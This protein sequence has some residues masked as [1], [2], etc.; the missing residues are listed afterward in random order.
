[1]ARTKKSTLSATSTTKKSRTATKVAEENTLSTS[2]KTSSANSYT[3]ERVSISELSSAQSLTDTDLVLVSTTNGQVSKNATMRTV[4]DY[5]VSK[6]PTSPSTGGNISPRTYENYKSIKNYLTETSLS[7]GANERFGYE[8]TKRLSAVIEGESTFGG[9]KTF[10]QLP[11]TSETVTSESSLS[12]LVTKQYVDDEIAKLGNTGGSYVPLLRWDVLPISPDGNIIS[13]KYKGTPRITG[14]PEPTTEYCVHPNTSGRTFCYMKEPYTNFSDIIFV[15]GLSEPD[16]NDANPTWYDKRLYAQN[17][18]KYDTKLLELYFEKLFKRSDLSNVGNWVYNGFNV[19]DTYSERGLDGS[20]FIINTRHS[21]YLNTTTPLHS[22]VS[23]GFFINENNN[24][25]DAKTIYEIYGVTRKDDKQVKQPTKHICD[26]NCNYN[27][28]VPS[29]LSSKSDTIDLKSDKYYAESQYYQ[30]KETDLENINQPYNSKWDNQL[31]FT[32]FSV[33]RTKNTLL[34]STFNN[35]LS[36]VPYYKLRLVVQRCKLEDGSIN[37]NWEYNNS[38]LTAWDILDEFGTES[39][40]NP[41]SGDIKAL[42][43][44]IPQEQYYDNDGYFRVDVS[45]Y[46]LEVGDRFKMVSFF[47]YNGYGIPNKTDKSVYASSTQ[48]MGYSNIRTQ[49][50]GMRLLA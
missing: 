4:A 16:N 34:S 14:W 47:K 50:Y 18:T 46:K 42:N 9:K 20:Y 27:T 33:G 17:F 31:M 1:M 8:V 39:V 2:Q 26:L 13:A 29:D 19:S 7:V 21:D 5:V 24:Y 30:I 32:I 43:G 37:P 28:T 48:L 44:S 38:D 25:T 36:S 41:V 3:F 45:K 22:M 11:D 15:I 12:S 10:S 6:V 49:Y 40:T 23:F 35:K